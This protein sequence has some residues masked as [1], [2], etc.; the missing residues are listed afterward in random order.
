[1]ETTTTPSLTWPET[2]FGDALLAAGLLVLG[3][4]TRLPFRSQVLYH[5]D[6][7]NFALATEHF[8][9]AT[10]QPQPPGYLLYVLLGRLVNQGTGDPQVS[11]V[12]LSVVFTGL[13]IA[14]MFILGTAMFDRQ[15]GLAAALLLWSSPL[16][17]FYGEVA[18]P[19]TLD[20]FFVILAAFLFYQVKQGRYEYL[21]PAALVLGI[22]GGFRPQTLLF[23]LPLS[24]YAVWPI[25]PRKLILPLA[26]LT[27]TCLSWVVPLLALSGGLVKYQE[28]TAAFSAS[29]QYFDA[30]RLLLQG[31]ATA[32]GRNASKLLRYTV[33]AMGPALL[34]LVFPLVSARR[35]SALWTP[36]IAFLLIWSLP[37]VI[38]YLFVHMGQQGLIFVFLPVLLLMSARCLTGLG[39]FVPHGDRLAQTLALMIGLTGAL[40]FILSPEYPFG[41]DLKVLSWKT[42]EN[43]DRQYRNLFSAIRG[44]FSPADTV[45]LAADWRTAGYYLPEFECLHVPPPRSSELGSALLPESENRFSLAQEDGNLGS[46]ERVNVVLFDNT[47]NGN[48]DQSW[49]QTETTT[50]GTGL[51][52]FKLSREE[53]IMWGADWLE[54]K[55]VAPQ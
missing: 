38:F 55:K 8:D 14:A 52:Y 44:G 37:A 33:Y 50:N 34:P 32:L 30:T 9:I 10:G 19:H 53:V 42:I 23:L 31:D 18:L 16:F 17:W 1:M 27:I 2:T 40:T 54:V 3:I 48:G 51:R 43:H 39:S 36:K 24:A 11:F 35:S 46:H 20:A 6:S 13:S 12:S 45:I 29:F 5:W 25:G 28:I 7:V 4:V 22:A 47:F 26:L 41:Q 21:T 49:I 15:T